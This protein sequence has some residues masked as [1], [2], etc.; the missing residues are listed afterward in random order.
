MFESLESA[1]KSKIFWI[2]TVFF[3]FY[4]Y[5]KVVVYSYWKRH[6]VPHAKPL[7]PLGNL[8]KDFF[9]KKIT[10]GKHNFNTNIKLYVCIEIYYITTIT[11]S[12][13][14]RR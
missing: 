14:T 7:I 12:F 3:V 6:G 11:V 2:T 4:L 5:F 10:F 8:S 13:A 9:M 1:V